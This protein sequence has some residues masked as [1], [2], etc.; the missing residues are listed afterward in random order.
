MRGKFVFAVLL[1]ATAAWLV[2]ESTSFAGHHR[3][4]GGCGG[5]QTACSTGCNTGC[6]TG[7]D[8]GCDTGCGSV[9]CETAVPATE[10]APAAEPAPPV[11]PAA[12]APVKQ[13]SP[14]VQAMTTEPS[15]GNYYSASRRVRRGGFRR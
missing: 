14:V 5:R 4:R 12:S 13:A 6:S 10:A 9:P 11:P 1:T 15:R 2:A 7:C 3:R 8:T